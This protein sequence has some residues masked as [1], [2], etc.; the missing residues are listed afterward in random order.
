MNGAVPSTAVSWTVI[1]FVLKDFPY[2]CRSSCTWG[3]GNVFWLSKVTGA[4][5]SDTWSTCSFPSRRSPGL[6]GT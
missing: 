2:A 1:H 6:L 3:V 5:L 4:P